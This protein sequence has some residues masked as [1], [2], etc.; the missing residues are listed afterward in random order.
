MRR[1]SAYNF[2][3]YKITGTGLP[4]NNDQI[5]QIPRIKDL[6][7]DERPREKLIKGGVKSLSS[8][9]LLAIILNTGTKKEEIISLSTRL[10]REYGEKGLAYQKNPK[11]IEEDLKIPLIK[12]CQIVACF[13]LG[14]RFCQKKSGRLIPIRTAAQAYNYLKD[15]GQLNKE[16]VRGLYL[17]AHYQ[18]IYDEVISLGTLTTSLIEPREVF[19]PALEHSAVAVIIAHNHPS[20]ILKPSTADQEITNNLVAAG[21]ILNIKVL[22]HLII[23]KNKFISII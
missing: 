7:S 13:E 17:N 10:L 5:Y 14:H 6:P 2:M 4:L 22:D 15:M 19:R 18:L 3:T 12:A 20:G 1:D 11:T 23:G 9:E 21:Q 8:T 16:Q